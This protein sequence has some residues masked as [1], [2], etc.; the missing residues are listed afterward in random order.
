MGLV[1]DRAIE[2]DVAGDQKPLKVVVEEDQT[3]TNIS[4]IIVLPDVK[5]TSFATF[6]FQRKNKKWKRRSTLGLD[7][8]R[9][10]Q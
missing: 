7:Y 10:R 5:L 6:F 4:C 8:D 3:L 1:T 2:S 9:K